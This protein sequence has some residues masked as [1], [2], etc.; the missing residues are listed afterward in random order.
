[1]LIV[2]MRNPKI[3]I[4]LVSLLF[5]A[6]NTVFAQSCQPF[7]DSLNAMVA[8]DQAIRISPW[9]EE[10]SQKM[11]VIDSTNTAHLK[12][13]IA[14]YGF[15][16][17]SLV[18]FAASNQAWLI[19]Q[20]SN[21]EFLGE[22]LKSYRRAVKENNAE[23]AN[24]ALMEDRQRMN[25]GLP[26]LYGSQL[27][28]NNAFFPIAN[29]DGVDERRQAM[30]LEPIKEYARRFNLDTIV[31]ADFFFNYYSYYL[32]LRNAFDSYWEGDY[33]KTISS[34]GTLH[35]PFPRDLKLLCD[36]YLASN[37]TL[38]A[39]ATARKMVL[40][41][42]RLEEDTL[43]DGFLRDS[44]A[45]EYAA[46]VE[47]YRL[48][49]DDK[50][51]VLFDSTQSFNA[52]KELLDA[53]QCP[54]YSIDA[55]NNIIPYIIQKQAELVSEIEHLKF[56]DWLYEQVI[57]GNYHLFDYAELYDE[58]YCRLFGK[59]YY[60]QKTFDKEVPL[61]EEEKVNERRGE[62]QLPSIEVWEEIKG[63]SYHIKLDT[64]HQ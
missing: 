24:L 31:V 32:N 27:F 19:A 21:P 30:G 42:Y 23:K 46:L 13:L 36:A 39:V 14:Q 4:L 10:N 50:T 2:D 52:I 63:M 56:F 15:P 8:R 60:G 53:K 37:D 57:I 20:H 38:K 35:Y 43:S 26:Q 47:E 33:P 45:K 40:C 16:T 62:I 49:L 44:V 11:A 29:I 59:S 28:G 61:F 22:F 5:A 51:N 18:G 1:M 17:W 6:V 25:E 12:A 3:L 7:I 48:Q 55:W 58:V 54:R 9:N 64:E 34:F 41:G